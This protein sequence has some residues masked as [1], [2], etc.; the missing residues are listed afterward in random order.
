[1]APKLLLEAETL[2]Y[3]EE[4]ENFDAAAESLEELGYVVELRLGGN[5]RD[6]VGAGLAVVLYLGEHIGDAA[7][8]VLVER[9]FQKLRFRPARQPAGPGTRRFVLIGENGE[10][11]K[12]IEIEKD[13]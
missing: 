5:E 1:M 13:E 7:L 10:T 9:L 3:V 2:Q 4:R 11:L 12:E 8:G 6:P